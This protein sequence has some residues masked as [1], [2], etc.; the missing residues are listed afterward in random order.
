[1]PKRRKLKTASALPVKRC[2]TV[3]EPP[4]K[5]PVRVSKKKMSK[6]KVLATPEKSENDKKEYRV[7]ELENGLKCLLI[8]DLSYPLEKLDEEEAEEEEE[9]GSDEEGEEEEESDDENGDSDGESEDE[10]GGRPGG[11]ARS[12]GNCKS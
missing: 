2:K 10:E 5:A 11:G 1:M 12:T 8:A 7:I 6:V 3:E 9:E 4:F